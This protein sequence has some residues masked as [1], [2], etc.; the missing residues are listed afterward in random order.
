MGAIQVAWSDQ[1]FSLLSSDGKFPFNGR[2][3]CNKILLTG[4]CFITDIQNSVLRSNSKSIESD[5]HEGGHGSVNTGKADERMSSQAKMVM[6]IFFRRQA[7]LRSYRMPH[8]PEHHLLY[9]QK[10]Q[11][12]ESICKESRFLN[13]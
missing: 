10:T 3:L 2:K 1:L 4:L 7:D 8:L 13:D 12:F 5:D 9:F 11:V 6:M